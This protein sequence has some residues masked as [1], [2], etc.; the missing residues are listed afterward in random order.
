MKDD[1][2]TSSH[3]LIHAFLFKSLGEYTLLTW[4]WLA[5]PGKP[6]AALSTRP[7]HIPYWWFCESP[8][9]LELPSAPRWTAQTPKHPSPLGTKQKSSL[10]NQR[11]GQQN[12]VWARSRFEYV[13]ADPAVNPSLYQRNKFPES[14]LIQHPKREPWSQQQ[15]QSDNNPQLEHFKSHVR[16]LRPRDHVKS[17]IHV[18]LVAR[19][20]GRDVTTPWRCHTN[21]LCA[22]RTRGW[23]WRV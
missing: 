14:V 18:L 5:V 9:K 23:W 6:S 13:S 16:A 11:F 21:L 22:I 12:G 20:T 3:Y 19:G 10:T 1:C 15:Q 7:L 4:R 2:T 8:G 17:H